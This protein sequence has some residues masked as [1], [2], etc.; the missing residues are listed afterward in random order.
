MCIQWTSVLYSVIITWQSNPPIPQFNSPCTEFT[1][2]WSMFTCST[3]TISLLFCLSWTN[4]LEVV[5]NR[6]LVTLLSNSVWF[7]YEKYQWLGT[8]NVL[9]IIL[10]PILDIFNCPMETSGQ[11]ES[12]RKIHLNNAHSYTQGSVGQECT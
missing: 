1:S 7:E 2:V 8:Y 6:T 9:A 3:S 4:G 11:H 5:R 12:T 10:V